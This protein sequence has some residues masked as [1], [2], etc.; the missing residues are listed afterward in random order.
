MLHETLRVLIVLNFTIIIENKL[1]LS[2]L[3][4]SLHANSQS[5]FAVTELAFL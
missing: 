1:L 4:L 5:N 2:V 3:L